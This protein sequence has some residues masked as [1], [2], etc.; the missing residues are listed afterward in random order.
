VYGHIYKITNNVNGKIYIGKTIKDI[1]VRFREHLTTSD[2]YHYNVVNNIKQKQSL[3]YPAIYKYG[4]DN[5]SI[6]CI[7]TANDK[8]ELNQKEIY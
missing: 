2:R 3:L 7:D 6:E 1:N 4:K 5:F 8:Y